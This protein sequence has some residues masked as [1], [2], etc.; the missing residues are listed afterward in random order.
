[1]IRTGALI[2]DIR[3][4]IHDGQAD[5]YVAVTMSGELRTVSVTELDL[6]QLHRLRV[7]R[8]PTRGPPLCSEP[9]G[10]SPDGE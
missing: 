8:R 2:I 6:P 3:T 7:G 4:G 5:T 1:M 10:Q 9:P